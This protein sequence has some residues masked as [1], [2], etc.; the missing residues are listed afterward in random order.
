MDTLAISPPVAT[1]AMRQP[2]P[3]TAPAFVDRAL[4]C[5]HTHRGRPAELLSAALARDP[6]N[7]AAHRLRCGMI[8]AADRRAARAELADSLVRLD[9]A[10][11]GDRRHADAARAWLEGD[12]GGALER[13]GAIVID[14]P[15][16]L[17]ALLVAHAL[18][19][20]L[21]RRRMLRDRVAQVLPAWRTPMEGHASVLAMYA[22]GLVE[23][24]QHASAEA[25]A[26]RALDIDAAHPGAVHV[27]AHVMDMEGRARQGLNFLA[28]NEDAMREP[29]AFAVHLEWHRALFHFEQD[30][31]EAAL[32]IHDARIAGAKVQGVSVLADASALLWRLGLR[33]TD[34]GW[35]WEVLADR[36]EAQAL[37]T[38]QPFFAMHATMAFAATGRA[39]AATRASAAFRSGAALAWYPESL[40][41]EPLC[42]ALMAFGD[43]A[44]E[45]CI[46]R[47][48]EVRDIAH[49]CGGSL[50][51]CDIVQLT[52]TEAAL[53]ARRASLA[54]ALIAER[55]AQKP[56]SRFTRLLRERVRRLLAKAA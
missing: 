27:V 51:Q 30:E 12:T 23:N 41:A 52:H 43:G 54:R 21:G 20:R 24:G 40:L 47:M 26:R 10:P 19:F 38:L 7:A 45:R 46:A 16:D 17:L 15:F 56:A 34:L 33:G 31:L 42:G 2:T 36:W 22:F 32:R 49:R 8:V 50:A 28:R 37:E 35:R 5:L 55:E 3:D 11:G 9:A 1:R 48:E 4:W 29:N 53:R 6:G 25:V 18:D 44:Y 14:Q 13:Y 39:D